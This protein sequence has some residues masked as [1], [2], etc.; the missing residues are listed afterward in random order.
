M[1]S[2][3]SYQLEHPLRC[4]CEL[5]PVL[6]TYGIDEQG[7]LYVHIIIRKSKR[8]HGELIARGDVQL[9]CRDCARWHTIKIVQPNE[10]KLK[11]TQTPPM[12][13]AG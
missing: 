8:I 4:F 7:E 3:N 11:E 6:G 9:K 13:V 2:E 10:M 1:K 12:L 5:A